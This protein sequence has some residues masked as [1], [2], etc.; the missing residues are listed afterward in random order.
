MNISDSPIGLNEIDKN[1]REELT[2]SKL[3]DR[4]A[5]VTVEDDSKTQANNYRS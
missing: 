4:T 2:S 5:P 3:K 1:H